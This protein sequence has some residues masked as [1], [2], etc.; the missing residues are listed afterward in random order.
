MLI[1]RTETTPSPRIDAHVVQL[2]GTGFDIH[3][4]IEM[5]RSSY[6]DYET[7][8]EW[9]ESVVE[10]NEQ[11]LRGL[12]DEYYRRL[13]VLPFPITMENG[14]V[15]CPKYGNQPLINT[16]SPEER[17]GTI[18]KSI[19]ELEEKLLCS[20]H[21]DSFVLISPPGWSG[22]NGISYPEAQV[23]FY[24]NRGGA[25]ESMTFVSKMSLDGSEDLHEVL[26]GNTL[27]R[28][29]GEIERITALTSALIETSVTSHDVVDAIESVTG[30]SMAHMR[31]CLNRY[32]E[33]EA[34][35]K[36]RIQQFS[37]F[38]RQNIRDNSDAS[39]ATLLYEMGRTVLD[40]KSLSVI[41]RTPQTAAE[42]TAAYEAFQEDGGCNGGGGTYVETP[43]G[44]RLIEGEE[45][46]PNTGICAMES[47]KACISEK[48]GSEQA[49]GLCMI[50]KTCD[51]AFQSGKSLEDIKK[52]AERKRA[53]KPT[54]TLEI[55][56]PN[57]I[58]NI[59]AQ[60]FAAFLF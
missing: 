13:P 45:E 50:C 18:Y 33:I 1:E 9:I 20:K 54:E 17:N 29:R 48:A 42:Y 12:H 10:K 34:H 4:Q 7:P 37:E 8:S 38:T 15:V 22:Y 14:R 46:F 49:L 41:G 35:I 59:A 30:E 23:Y 27:N 32:P 5:I 40:M 58:L 16:V 25:I 19:Q 28:N 55:T 21:N 31:M 3:G 57:V 52:I 36:N 53:K 44:A 39:M 43:F 6:G 60:L 47:L 56:E 24:R 2:K 51:R 26:N 11:D